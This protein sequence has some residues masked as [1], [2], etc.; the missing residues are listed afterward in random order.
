MV[1]NHLFTNLVLTISMVI[2]DQA[3]WTNLD[4]RTLDEQ[5]YC[6]LVIESDFDLSLVDS[7]KMYVTRKPA[8][9]CHPS[10]V[11]RDLSSMDRTTCPDNNHPL[12]KDPNVTFL[13]WNDL[14]ID[15]DELLDESLFR[16]MPCNLPFQPYFFLLTQSYPDQFTVEEIQIFIQSK[17]QVMTL[18]QNKDGSWNVNDSSLV[19]IYSRR[20]NFHGMTIK[21]HF[22]DKTFGYIDESKKFTG[23]NGDLATLVANKLN[24]SL[25]LIEIQSWGIKTENGTFTGTLNDLKENHIDVGKFWI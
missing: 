11:L 3:I 5:I 19:D 6:Q 18:F 8:P 1:Q 4:L 15:S 7:T 2:C 20:S 16:A 22:D 24:F 12:I 9:D 14:A 21:S 17:S 13:F 25:E 10:L 23:Y